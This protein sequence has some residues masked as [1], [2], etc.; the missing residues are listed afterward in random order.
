MLNDKFKKSSKPT[1]EYM[2]R[3]A[4]S[5]VCVTDLCKIL[6]KKERKRKHA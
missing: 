5:L 2:A 3:K 1:Q 4:L 6:K